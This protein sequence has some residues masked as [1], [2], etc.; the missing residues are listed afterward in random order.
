MKREL[1]SLRLAPLIK[2]KCRKSLKGMVI[3]RRKTQNLSR[4]S[5]ELFSPALSEATWLLCQEE[6]YITSDVTF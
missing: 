3:A 4:C 6:V 5:K 2:A 1:V